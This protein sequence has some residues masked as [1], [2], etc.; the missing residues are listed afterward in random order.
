[1]PLRAEWELTRSPVTTPLE[2]AKVKVSSGRTAAN[3]IIFKS[4]VMRF[5]E[6][7]VSVA[8]MKES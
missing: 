5:M 7:S 3:E 8:I 6:N 1:V 2:I 4:L